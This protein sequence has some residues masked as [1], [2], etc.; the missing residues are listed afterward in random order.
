MQK[1]NSN[2][3]LPI[4]QSPFLSDLILDGTAN[5]YQSSYGQWSIQFRWVR[6]TF[7]THFWRISQKSKRLHIQICRL[8][9]LHTTHLDETIVLNRSIVEVCKRGRSKSFHPAKN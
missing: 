7:C 9:Y 6:R 5:N 8:Q 3:I 2:K 1:T 4:E